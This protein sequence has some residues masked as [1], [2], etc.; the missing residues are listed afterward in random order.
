MQL[1][2]PLRRW[3]AGSALTWFPC[4]PCPRLPCPPPLLPQNLTKRKLAAVN[5]G[6]H[7]IYI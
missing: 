4:L 5:A 6:E 2:L 3:Q 7:D 1:E